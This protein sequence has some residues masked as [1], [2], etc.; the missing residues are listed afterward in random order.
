MMKDN[1]PER[2]SHGSGIVK[3]SEFA[4]LGKNVVLEPGVLVFFPES[5]EIGDRVYVGHYTILKGYHKNRMIIGDGTWIGQM[6]FFHSAGGLRIGKNVGI[7]PGVQI[8]TSSHEG[9]DLNVSIIHTKL[10]FKEV[11][12]EDECDIGVGSIILSGVTIGR[13]AQ[14]GAGAVVTKNVEPFSVV[15]GVPARLIRYRKE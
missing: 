14:V 15:A 12:I 13:G 4:R 2:F 10:V 6:C 3:P 7:G 8:L 9:K 11:I 1:F 5:I